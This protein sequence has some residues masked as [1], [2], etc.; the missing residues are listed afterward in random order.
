MSD[1][2]ETTEVPVPSNEELIQEL[3]YFQ[4]HQM[5]AL[6]RIYDL[7][8]YFVDKDANDGGNTAKKIQERHKAH[9]YKWPE[10]E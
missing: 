8:M 4:A 10:G 3:R 5:V 1:E 9:N 6:E 2:T 7:L